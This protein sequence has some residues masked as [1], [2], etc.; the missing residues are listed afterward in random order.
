MSPRLFVPLTGVNNRVF[1]T[2]SFVDLAFLFALKG[3]QHVTA[4]N[5]DVS[6]L[7][8][9]V[10]EVFDLNRGVRVTLRP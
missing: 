4:E 3:A 7:S 2:D 1:G 9:F 8:Y 5:I 6:Y 10:P